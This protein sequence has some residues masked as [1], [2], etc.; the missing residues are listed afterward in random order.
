LL[1]KSRWTVVHN[2]IEI[3]NTDIFNENLRSVSL[4]YRWMH[5]DRKVQL[6]EAKNGVAGCKDKK[7]EMGVGSGEWGVGNRDPKTTDRTLD[8]VTPEKFSIFGSQASDRDGRMI[9]IEK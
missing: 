9:K 7:L 4:S 8:S 1:L 3:T 6:V 2:S 5:P